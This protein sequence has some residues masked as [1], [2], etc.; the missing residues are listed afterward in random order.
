EILFRAD[1]PSDLARRG[2]GDF[3]SL[4]GKLPATKLIATHDLE[5]AVE[6]CTRVIV[7]DRGVVVADGPTHQLLDDEALMLAHGLER[8]HILRHIH[9]H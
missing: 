2:G 6:L 4:L 8:P 9:P 1:P 7:L 3:K 5:L